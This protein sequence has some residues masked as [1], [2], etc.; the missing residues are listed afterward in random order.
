MLAHGMKVD[1]A[2]LRRW[3]PR[4]QGATMN[5]SIISAGI[6]LAMPAAIM[7]AGKRAPMLNY[8]GSTLQ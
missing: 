6:C 7:A 4:K 1:A 3:L 8:Q 5:T 2:S